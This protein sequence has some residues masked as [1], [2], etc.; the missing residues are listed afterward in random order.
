VKIQ[1]RVKPRS[2]KQ[3]FRR[4]EDGTFTASLN[5]APVEG[6]ANEELVRLVADHFG[7]RKSQ[8]TI[9]SGELARIKILEIENE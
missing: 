3:L 9:N 1:V 8:V 7:V 5:A 4:E 6:K 2:R